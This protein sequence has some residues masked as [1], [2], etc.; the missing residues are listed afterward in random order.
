M[1]SSASKCSQCPVV[2]IVRDPAGLVFEVFSIVGRSFLERLM[3]EVDLYSR[4]EEKDAYDSAVITKLI[5][6]FRSH[7]DILNISN[8]LF[9]HKELK[10]PNW[11]DKTSGRTAQPSPGATNIEAPCRDFGRVDLI[12]TDPSFLHSS[13]ERASELMCTAMREEH[14]SPLKSRRHQ[15]LH[16]PRFPVTV[17]G[18]PEIT[19]ACNWLELP[20]K[21]FPIIFHGIVGKDEREA[22]SPSYFN[23]QEIDLVLSYVGKLLQ[24]RLSGRKIN[25][26][27]IGIVTPYRK[28][29]TDKIGDTCLKA[30]DKIGDTCLKATDKIGDTCLKA[31]DKIGDTCRKATD[32][33]GDICQKATDKIGDTCLKATDKIGDTCRKATDKIGDTCLK[34]TDKI[35]CVLGVE[36]EDNLLEIRDIVGFVTCQDSNHC[37][38][39]CVLGVEEEDNLLEISDIVGFVTCQDSNHCCLVC[40]LGVEEE[41]NLL[42]ISDIV[43]FAQKFKQA[44][45]K[46]NWQEVSVGSVEE[47]QGQERLIIIIST[48]R[49]SHELLEDDYK[50]RLG[51][52]DNPKRFNVA[53]TRAKSLLI[54]VG[55]PNILQCD[56]YW[57]Q[58]LNYCHKNNAYRGVKFPLHEKSPVDRLI[59]DMK[60]LDINTAETEKPLV[61]GKAAKLRCFRNT[62]IRKHPVE[63]RSNKKP[64]KMSHIMGEWGWGVCPCEGSVENYPQYTL[65]RFKPGSP[66]LVYCKSSALDHTATEDMQFRV[67]F[68][69]RYEELNLHSTLHFHGP[70]REREK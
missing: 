49:S 32:K 58:L 4:D 55:N 26:K 60:Q 16:Y 22:S 11:L 12:Q 6:N 57:H 38:L 33:I 51:F 43:G 7:K 20:K 21:G 39:V 48:V 64:W 69:T 67:S 5:K 3:D 56:Y 54:V 61:I 17:C 66:S 10:P 46:K 53:M 45:N 28:Q 35:V 1:S 65:P 70:E 36:E 52:L 68:P 18:G 30:I 41:D 2:L 13:I 47:F 31:T 15:T 29:A 44:M 42:E 24:D 25:Q 27:E 40:V 50:F 14:F 37:C 23:V 8:S 59:K 19:L 62:A 34:A 63:W 9:Y